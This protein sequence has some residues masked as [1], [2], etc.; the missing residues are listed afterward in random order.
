MILHPLPALPIQR[1]E[2]NH[3][4]ST[5]A[6]ILPVLPPILLAALETPAAALLIPDPAELVTLLK[7]SV[8]L[9]CTFFAV[10][11]AFSVVVEAYLRVASWRDWRK[12]AREEVDIAIDIA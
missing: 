6:I 11:A 10:S 9:L 2:R 4:R 1:N 8:A 5:K 12:S 3:L 7:P